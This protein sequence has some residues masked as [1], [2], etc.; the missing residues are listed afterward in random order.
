MG[1]KKKADAAKS[2][3]TA[4]KE[5]TLDEVLAGVVNSYGIISRVAENMGCTWGTAK[6]YVDSYPE[7]V[8]LFQEETERV[9]DLAESKV[10]KS[11]NMD[12]VGTAKWLLS[13]KGKDR[14]YGEQKDVRIS[15]Q[16]DTGR[17]DALSIDELRTLVKLMEKARAE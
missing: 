14:G 1:N 12:D 5:Y 6:K 13:T 17:A 15:G 16:I 11:I 3:K 8:Q 9:L 7:A 10:I 2:N 4:A